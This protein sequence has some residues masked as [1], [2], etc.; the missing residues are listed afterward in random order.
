MKTA[1]KFI[2]SKLEIEIKYYRKKH[3]NNKNIEKD[4]DHLIYNSNY[5]NFLIS[6]K[7]N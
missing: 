7:N 1:K 2:F 3:Y 4:I 6:L 5:S